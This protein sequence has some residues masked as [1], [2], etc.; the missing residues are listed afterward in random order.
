MAETLLADFTG[1]DVAALARAGYVGFVRY[2]DFLPNSKVITKAEYDLILQLGKV[3]ILNWENLADDMRRGAGVG[4]VHAFEANRQANALGHPMD[5]PIFY[6][7]DWDAQP[8]DYD[9]VEAYLRAAGGAGGSLISGLRPAGIY[10]KRA[11]MEE[12][13]RRGAA[14]PGGWE[15]VAWSDGIISPMA[16]LYQRLTPTI[17]PADGSIDEDIVVNDAVD[18][19]QH[20]FVGQGPAANTPTFKKKATHHA[21]QHR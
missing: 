9:A 6:S 3:I 14:W 16:T 17:W 19:G 20:P 13:I 15:P 10:G 8:S 12:M 21:S 11:L 1:G 5:R 2:L 7:A 18:Y 4:A